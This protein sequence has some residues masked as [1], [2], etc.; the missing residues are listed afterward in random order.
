ME[1]DLT[2]LVAGFGA[3]GA[4]ALGAVEAG[5]AGLGRSVEPLAASLLR[6]SRSLTITNQPMSKET[7]PP[8]S[9]KPE[10]TSV[11]PLRVTCGWG[12]VSASDGNT[13]PEP[14][15]IRPVPPPLLLEPELVEGLLFPAIPPCH[16][17]VPE[18]VD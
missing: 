8:L 13:G 3:V 18:P 10:T 9:M 12:G 14:G 1:S 15:T 11:R 16:E 2:V 4:A 5:L 6:A 17:Q 7:N